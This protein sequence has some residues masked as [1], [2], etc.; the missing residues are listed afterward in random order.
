[1]L[2]LL[3]ILRRRCFMSQPIAKKLI[4]L[5]QRKPCPVQY[6]ELCGRLQGHTFSFGHEKPD[7]DKHTQAKTPK[8]EISPFTPVWSEMAG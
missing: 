3:G 4:H 8:N 2:G 6:R 1:M 7:K 5:L